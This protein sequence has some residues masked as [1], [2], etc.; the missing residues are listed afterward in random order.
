MLLSHHLANAPR[1]YLVFLFVV[2]FGKKKT[3]L[4][5]MRETL[6]LKPSSSTN[7]STVSTVCLSFMD[8]SMMP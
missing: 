1:I 2:F 7:T 6:H 5:R 4:V 8:N 3:R